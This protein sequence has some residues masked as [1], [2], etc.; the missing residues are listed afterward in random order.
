MAFLTPQR[1]SLNNLPIFTQTHQSPPRQCQ[2]ECFSNLKLTQNHLGFKL[3][4]LLVF[5]AFCQSVM[6]WNKLWAAGA[7]E[8][9]S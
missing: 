6:K 3:G 1:N 8:K 9:M 4:F 5:W 2:E 7:A